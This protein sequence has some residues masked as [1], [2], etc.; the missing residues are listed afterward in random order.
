MNSTTQKLILASS[1]P[2][3]ADLLK[4]AGISFQVIPPVADE[5]LHPGET[6]VEFAI[7]T[8]REKA[9][10]VD[11][12]DRMVM[13]ADT[14]V[15][16]EGKILGKPEDA[17]E[18]QAMLRIL[19]GKKHEVITGVCIRTQEKTRCFHVATSVLFLELSDK[20]ILAYVESGEPMDKAGAYAI[21]G[22]AAGMVR[23][24]DGSYSNIVGL[25]LCEIIEELEAL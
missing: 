15:V 21:Q 16:I 19:S 13:G 14:T 5:R 18:A 20:E 6:P 7:R 25:P 4:Q 23:R 12:E 11:V 2:R 17:T 3:R 22:G 9:E 1:S 24:I 10:S 8:A